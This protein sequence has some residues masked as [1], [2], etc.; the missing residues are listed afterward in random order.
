M[1]FKVK[2]IKST[3]RTTTTFTRRK[4]FQYVT[5]K[6]N[7]RTGNRGISEKNSSL[8]FVRTNYPSFFQISEAHQ[9]NMRPIVLLSQTNYGAS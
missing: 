1:S 9:C 2:K 8:R 5:Y 4:S 7:L 3:H 6:I